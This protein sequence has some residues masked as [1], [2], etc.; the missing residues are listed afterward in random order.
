MFKIH[1]SPEHFI[2]LILFGGPRPTSRVEDASAAF[3]FYD[4][5]TKY[6]QRLCVM[7]DD[8]QL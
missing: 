4:P 5:S 8:V 6:P 2:K 3:V 7:S 1:L